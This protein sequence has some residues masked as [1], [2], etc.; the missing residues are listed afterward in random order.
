[1]LYEKNDLDHK[2]SLFLLHLQR[3]D[4]K[5]VDLYRLMRLANAVKKEL[6]VVLYTDEDRAIDKVELE[7]SIA[8][9]NI[10]ILL[11]G[12]K[13]MKEFKLSFIK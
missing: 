12:I 10:D 8:T 4:C 3:G 1:M 6:M 5:W 7:H 13:V 9:K 2:H 11:Y